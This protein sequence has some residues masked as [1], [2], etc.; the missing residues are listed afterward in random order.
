MEK[1]PLAALVMVQGEGATMAS[2]PNLGNR[3]LGGLVPLATEQ[4]SG[5]GPWGWAAWLPRPGWVPILRYHRIHPAPGVLAVSPE[6]FAAH[7]RL[8]RRYFVPVTLGELADALARGTRLPRLGAVVTFD[9]GYQDH[10]RYAF[11]ILQAFEIPATF[12]VAPERIDRPEEG[13]G[14]QAMS[15]AELCELAA[16][17]MEIGARPVSPPSLLRPSLTV[18][19]NELLAAKERLE[20][21]LGTEVR[22]FAHPDARACGVSEAL[23]RL[24]AMS[25]YRSACSSIE[26]FVTRRTPLYMLER[27]GVGAELAP[28]QL[29]VKL[30]GLVRHG[31]PR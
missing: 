25:G 14:R 22:H 6:V 26:G 17:G 18:A 11:P 21:Q 19:A 23:A 31:E 5:L 7:M 20:R 1:D 24:V 4:V 3:G 9:D 30:A 8:L 28:H 15:W 13:A 29:L 10:Y 12:F 27:I 16:A 2:D